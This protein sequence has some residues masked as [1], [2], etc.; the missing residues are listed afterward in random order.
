ANGIRKTAVIRMGRCARDRRARNT[1][2]IV[3]HDRAASCSSQHIAQGFMNFFINRHRWFCERLVIS[4]DYERI[5]QIFTMKNNPTAGPTANGIAFT[6]V[7]G[8]LNKSAE[9][10]KRK[11]RGLPP[12]KSNQ[13]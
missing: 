1:W 13:R 7:L 5:R 8:D 2:T 12:I 3:S 9:V 10:S 6:R 11:G 4:G